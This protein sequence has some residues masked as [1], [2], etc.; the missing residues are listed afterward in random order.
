MENICQWN[1]AQLVK[2]SAKL[3]AKNVMA[4]VPSL[5]TSRHPMTTNH[6]RIDA[7]LVTGAAR[8]SASSAMETDGS[9]EK[10]C[11]NQLRLFKRID[12]WISKCCAYEESCNSLMYLIACFSAAIFLLD[13][14]M[15]YFSERSFKFC[16]GWSCI[17]GFSGRSSSSFEFDL[18]RAIFPICRIHASFQ[19]L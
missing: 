7:K 18:P 8:L 5:V 10:K 2:A 17:T 1:P 6:G 3:A 13:R 16:C 12:G 11:L 4:Q 15:K 19:T 14:A 9:L